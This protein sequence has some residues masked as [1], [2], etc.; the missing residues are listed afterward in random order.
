VVPSA[1]QTRGA[2][3]LR[4]RVLLPN[5]G[6]GTSTSFSYV[7]YTNLIGTTNANLRIAI[8]SAGG[9]GLHNGSTSFVYFT[10]SGAI[11]N[12]PLMDNSWVTFT[13]RCAT[14]PIEGAATRDHSAYSLW[15]GEQFQG[16]LIGS[17]AQINT[18]GTPFEIAIG[19]AAYA[20]SRPVYVDYIKWRRGFND[21]P[22]THTFR[23]GGYDQP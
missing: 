18:G 1:Y 14:T 17:T 4:A 7:R 13:L 16:T 23:G 8:P 19:K 2:W 6:G 11:P 22:P 10:G 20:T 3:E 9:A 15:V 5:C 12:G 21:A